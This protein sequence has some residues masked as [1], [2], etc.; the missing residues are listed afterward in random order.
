MYPMGVPAAPGRESFCYLI[1]E[2]LESGL[3]FDCPGIPGGA[4]PM[5]SAG[6]VTHW[7]AR[8]Q[9]GDR[10]AAQQLWERYFRR[11]VGLARDRLRGAPRGAADEEDVALS[12]FDSFCRGAEQGRFPRLHDRDNLWRLL[13][14]ITARKAQQ[15]AQRE[16]R[17]KRGGGVVLDEAA[18]AGPTG[19][20][21]EKA[22]LE[23]VLGA[24][25]TPEFAAQ[26][27]EECRRLLRA[28]GDAELEAV[29]LLKMEGYTTEEIA[30]KLGYV[31]RTIERK[32]RLIRGLWE[33]EAPL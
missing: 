33:S 6:S 11:L 9:A 5:S 3:L 19:A 15:L 32:L 2:G 14:V 24:E 1:P 18:L 12:A 20:V 23:G 4:P 10:E 21:P 8:L 30:A 28:L 31:P 25:P 16:R 27:A 7:L 13:V 29:A 17:Q 22:G 26:V